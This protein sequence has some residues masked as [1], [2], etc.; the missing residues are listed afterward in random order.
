MRILVVED[1]PTLRAQLVAA[2]T[3][4]GHTVEA[5]ADGRQAHYLGDVEA[6]DAVVLDLGLPML[7]GLSVLR[8]WRAAGR[9]MPVLI[10][11]AR[12]SWQEK[13]QGIDAGADDYLAKPFHMEELLARLRALLRR[14]SEHASS[15]WHCGAIALDTRSARV[16]VAGQPLVLTSH[17]FKLLQLLMQRKGEV[18]SRTELSEHLYPQDSDRDSNTIE[19]F[20]ARL[21]K[22]LPEGSIETVRGLGYRLVDADAGA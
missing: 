22:K 18:L 16:L 10:L 20:V 4:A 13:V 1:E 12:S 6:F 14:G 21:R 2:I 19:V 11:T 5:A 15:E 3:A 17:E 9:A 7:D 8:Q